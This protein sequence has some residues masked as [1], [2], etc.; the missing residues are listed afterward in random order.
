ML[1][2]IGGRRRRGRQRMRWLDGII[3]L[4]DVSLSELWVMVTDREARCAAIHGVAKS[5][6]WL[7]DWTERLNWVNVKWIFH[8]AN[9]PYTFSFQPNYFK[10]NNKKRTIQRRSYFQQLVYLPLKLQDTKCIHTVLNLGIYNCI[11][12]CSSHKF[13]II[14]CSSLFSLIPVFFTSSARPS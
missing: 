10:N 9:L 6:T 8:I 4:M 12:P 2:G 5:W 7:R 14:F 13:L 3:D 11:V 1:G